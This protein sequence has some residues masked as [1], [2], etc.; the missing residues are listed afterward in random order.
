MFRH[1]YQ[2]ISIEKAQS[3]PS[4]SVEYIYPAES[5]EIIIE[6]KYQDN[7]KLIC[8]QAFK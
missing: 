5:K 4:N 8:I 2:I 7:N 3:D 6:L 1:F